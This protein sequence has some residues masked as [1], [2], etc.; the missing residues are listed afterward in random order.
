MVLN[1]FPLSCET[2]FLTFSKRKHFGFLSD[3]ILA[4]SKNSVP[5]VSSKPSFLPA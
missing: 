3:S 4:I 5:L 2:K 1:V